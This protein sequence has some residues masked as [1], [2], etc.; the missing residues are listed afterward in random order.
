MDD[1]Q[2]FDEYVISYLSTGRDVLRFAAS[3]LHRPT[4]P[5]VVADPDFDLGNSE[6]S[7]AT[8][9][10]PFR[11][12]PGT[13]FEGQSIAAMLKVEPVL[14]HIALKRVVTSC[15]SP[16]VLHLATHAFFLPDQSGVQDLRVEVEE[17]EKGSYAGR[18]AAGW[19]DNPLLRAGLVFAGANTWLAGY[20]LPPEAEDTILTAED[21]SVLDLDS[22]ELVVLSASDTGL[23][24]VQVD[25]SVFWLYRA[26]IVAG[27]RTVIA[28]R[29]NAPDLQTSELMLSFYQ[30]LHTGMPRAD[31]LRHALQNMRAKNPHPYYWSGFVCY[32]DPGPL[33]FH[34]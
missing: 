13:R 29:W 6:G 21:A 5:L 17:A 1:R 8:G 26:F 25:E 23:G 12:L 28:S 4:S 30:Y 34:T 24:D 10:R 7:W 27:A 14:G 18:I 19:R 9:G 16:F 33:L 3:R 15:H 32:G 20:P 22:T 11:R 2:L 31:A